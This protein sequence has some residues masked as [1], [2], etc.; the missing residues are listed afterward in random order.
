VLKRAYF[1]S[2]YFYFIFK[3]DKVDAQN[4]SLICKIQYEI[5]KVKINSLVSIG[6]IFLFLAS[7]RPN[8]FQRLSTIEADTPELSSFIKK[9][10]IYAFVVFIWLIA[11]SAIYLI[12]RSKPLFKWT[13]FALIAISTI[14]FDIFFAVSN[15]T[16]LYGD[17]LGLRLAVA[18]I[19]NAFSEY[20]SFILYPFFRLSLLF[21]AFLILQPYLIRKSA[22]KALMLASLLL[23][24][25]LASFVGI[26]I[27]KETAIGKMPGFL[28]IY[29]FEIANLLDQKKHN[30]NHDVILF[31]PGSKPRRENIVLIIDE[32]VRYDFINGEESSPGLNIKSNSIW[33]VYDYGS[34]TSG[35]NCSAYS[36][37]ILRKGPKP[38]HIGAEIQ[39]NPL[40]W[41]YAKK[42]GFRTTLIDAQRS[43]KGHDYFDQ[44]ELKMIDNNVNTGKYKSDRD[45]AI[46]LKTLLKNSGN[47]V[48][49]IKKGSHFPYSIRYPKTFAP[50]FKSAYINEKQNRIEYAR[51]I[52]YQTGG[53][54]EELLGESLT[55]PTLMVYTSDH[56]QNL[57][58]ISGTT[59]CTMTS[60]PYQGEGMVPMLI[61]DNEQ[62]EK[63][64]SYSHINHNKTSHFN[65]FSTLLYYLGY[66]QHDY[67]NH[68]GA[69]LIE[70]VKRFGYFN[71]GSPFGYFGTEPKFDSANETMDYIGAK[72]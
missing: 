24:M 45:A 65:I 32:S 44:E 36:N 21:V 29:G 67:F 1:I 38:D 60:D 42:A 19:D 27:K 68:Y 9:L 28:S 37:L 23:I 41:A 30:Y 47:F 66:E 52:M 2:T 71:Y 22:T 55:S 50:N 40:I 72:K 62:D 3:S 33:N 63:I 34:A 39:E 53:F 61:I 35:N 12:A 5:K 43:G 7:E 15:N 6:L 56:G 20:N 8:I 48:I 49:I 51:A 26:C 70:P 59:H 17:Y 57:N 31:G 58:D 4:F 64:L 25:C 18:D 14:V 69:S 13:A 54:F 46:E 16:L 11:L 10:L